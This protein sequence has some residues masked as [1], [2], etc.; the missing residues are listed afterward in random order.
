MQRRRL[1]RS[2]AR[3]AEERQN[4][5]GDLRAELGEHRDVAIR[6]QLD[7]FCRQVVANAVD[8]GQLVLLLSRDPRQRLGIVANRPRAVA[9]R[10]HAKGI[11]GLELEQVRNEVEGIGNLGVGH[12][13]NSGAGAK[14]GR[15]RDSHSL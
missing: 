12:A 6:N 7:D 2:D 3:D 11:R 4:A 15:I 9:I 10:P 13:R 5:L 14:N 1:L 8:L